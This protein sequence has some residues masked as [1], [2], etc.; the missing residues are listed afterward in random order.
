MIPFRDDYEVAQMMVRKF[1]DMRLPMNIKEAFWSNVVGNMTLKSR[2][3]NALPSFQDLDLV[4]NHGIRSFHQRSAIRETAFLESIGRCVDNIIAGPSTIYQAGRGA[5]ATRFLPKDTIITGSPLLIVSNRS[6]LHMYGSMKNDPKIR[7]ESDFIG[8]QLLLNYCMGHST[9]NIL[10]CPFGPMVNYINH[11]QARVNV[12]LQWPRH[13]DLSH[14]E[15]YLHMSDQQLKWNYS[16]N[17]AIDYV[18][19]RDIEPG[20]E[21]FLDYGDSFEEAWNRHL[22]SWKNADDYTS[23][24][25]FNEKM[26]DEVLRTQ[27]EQENDPYPSHL[28]VLCHY[29]LKRVWW[30]QKILDPSNAEKKGWPCDILSRNQTNDGTVTYKVR[31]FYDIRNEEMN[32][33]IRIPAIREGVPRKAITFEEK[34]GI[35]TEAA[36]RHE[37]GFPDNLVPTLWKNRQQ[38]LQPVE[39]F[40]TTTVKLFELFAGYFHVVAGAGTSFPTQTTSRYHSNGIGSSS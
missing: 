27:D 35:P 2:T 40:D 16:T 9:S 19:L 14:N 36:F 1:D 32:Q 20:E 4:A 30:E 5:F 38:Q 39:L 22:E 12:K 26:K 11:N 17:L 6:Y 8:H 34:T 10:L 24:T 18:A 29:A 3:L 37:I 15:T 33:Q 23:A 28:C 25:L 21:L 31:L 7:N 13:G